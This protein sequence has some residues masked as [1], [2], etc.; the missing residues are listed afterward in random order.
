MQSQPTQPVTPQ[1]A[2]QTAYAHDMETPSTSALRFNHNTALLTPGPMGTPQQSSGKLGEGIPPHSGHFEHKTA[3]ECNGGLW[4]M[5]MAA[6]GN[7]I[8]VDV[9]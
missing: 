1:Q 6:S 5:A 2:Y 9:V 8:T 7:M 3:A 4:T